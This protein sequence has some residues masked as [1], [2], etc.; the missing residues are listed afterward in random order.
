VGNFRHEV[1]WP[2]IYEH[3]N[4]FVDKP[5]MC[6]G[7]TWSVDANITWQA[8]PEEFKRVFGFDLSCVT[9]F[10]ACRTLDEFFPAAAQILKEDAVK[11]PNN[12]W[13]NIPCNARM[14]H[15]L[16]RDSDVVG[17]VRVGNVIADGRDFARIDYELLKLL[18][19]Q[20][21]QSKDVRYRRSFAEIGGR[22]THSVQVGFVRI[23]LLNETFGEQFSNS[24]C[25]VML[26]TPQN[27]SAVQEGIADDRSGV[28]E[29]R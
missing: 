12:V 3:P 18:K 24:S 20:H 19:G 8:S 6:T 1:G 26:P 17:L 10:R 9:R 28:L 7:C 22:A 25:A 14:A 23:V 16:G 29:A 13:G 2:E 21:M 11:R 27:M 4:V 5:S 15:I